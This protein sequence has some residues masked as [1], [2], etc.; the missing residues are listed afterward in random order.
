MAADKASF[1]LYSDLIHTVNKLTDEQAGQLFKHIL[2]YVNDENPVLENQLLE[3]AFEP[4]KQGLRRDLKKW[5]QKREQ[6]RQAGRKGG[7]KRAENLKGSQADVATAKNAKRPLADQAVSASVYVNAI[8]NRQYIDIL[9]EKKNTDYA[10]WLD[11]ICRK[12][13]LRSTRIWRV[14]DKFLEHLKATEKE[15]DGLGSFKQHF[16]HWLDKQD[17][18]QMLEEYKTRKIGAL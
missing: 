8:N 10:P 5:E 16:V 18:H 13:G 9:K 11:G 4:I 14:L 7:L 12:H 17:Q 1:L 3:V 6:A 15:H 2:A